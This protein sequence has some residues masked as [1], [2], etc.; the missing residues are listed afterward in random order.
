[1]GLRNSLRRPQRNTSGSGKGPGR[2]NRPRGREEAPRPGR[3]QAHHEAPLGPG[4]SGPESCKRAAPGNIRGQDTGKGW[5][6][7][8]GEAQRGGRGEWAEPGRGGCGGP[9]E[10]GGVREAPGNG[11]RGGVE[12]GPRRP[13]SVPTL[14]GA[15]SPRPLRTRRPLRLHLTHFRSARAL[16]PPAG[17]AGSCSPARLAHRL[18]AAPLH[19][20]PQQALRAPVRHFRLR[21][22]RGSARSPSG[23]ERDRGREMAAGAVTGRAHPA[24][25]G[26]ASSAV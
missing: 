24:R 3:A 4:Q 13:L 7:C 5:E 15:A 18:P 14:T 9:G 23:G 22:W 6:Q 8:R 11:R 2:P 16:C 17:A 20:S 25:P 10:E 26:P 1:M 19:Y 21:P 12:W